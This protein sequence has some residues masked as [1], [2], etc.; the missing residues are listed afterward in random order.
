LKK[1]NLYSATSLIKYN[2][3]IDHHQKGKG[4]QLLHY[5]STLQVLI[6]APYMSKYAFLSDS[7]KYKIITV[8]IETYG[9]TEVTCLWFYLSHAHELLCRANEFLG[10]AHEKIKSWAFVA[11]SCARESMLCRGSFIYPS[12]YGFESRQRL[13]FFHL[14]EAIKLAYGTS[15]VLLRFPFVH[16]GAPEVFL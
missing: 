2:E 3:I 5:M 15:V 8:A 9:G 16:E 1:C 13:G 10:R 11:M 14:M 4:R 6:T 7:T 12:R